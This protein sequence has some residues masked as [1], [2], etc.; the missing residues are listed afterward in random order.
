[1]ALNTAQLDALNASLADQQ[2]ENARLKSELAKKPKEVIKVQE[3]YKATGAPQSV[4]FNIGS[5]RLVSKKEIV[6]L[7]AIANVASTS[8][9]P[10]CRIEEVVFL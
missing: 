8:S 9:I 1:M 7:E 3:V 2:A 4:F 10:P 5:S 6:N